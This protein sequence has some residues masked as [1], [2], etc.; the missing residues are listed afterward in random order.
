MRMGVPQG[1]ILGPLIFICYV[2][3]LPKFCSNTVSFMYADDTALLARGRN[4]DTI[5]NNLQSDL[6][7]ILK[8]FAAN[9]LC[10]NTSKTKTMLFCSNRSSYKH[11]KLSITDGSERI[12]EVDTFKYLGLH[13]DKHLCFDKHIDK[14][15]GKVNQ[16]TGILWRMRN[17]INQPLAKYLYQTLIHP[18]FQY[19]DFLYDGCSIT[20]KQKLQVSQNSALRAV[21]KCARDYS[22]KQLHEDLEIDT[23]S[24]SRMKSTLKVVHRGV[25]NL[26]PTS[27]NNLFEIYTP[28]RALRSEN[29]CLLLPPRSKLKQ[30]EN[31]IAIRGCHYWNDIILELRQE[32][33][34]ETF[35]NALK[36]Y[37]TNYL[38]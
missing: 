34:T 21:R 20:L 28:G 10:I 38:E 8:W 32:V 12:E 1:S 22:T 16:R 29:L 7:Q 4:I 2:N 5:K 24:I 31:D 23:L 37:G 14:I 25:H 6:N 11:D 3:D 18:V 35:K 33:K 15:V 26:G 30:S 27:L 36:T 19:C 13:L 17:F 9:R